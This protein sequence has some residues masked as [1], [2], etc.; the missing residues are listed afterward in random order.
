VIGFRPWPSYDKEISV[1]LNRE[2][3]GGLQR[4]FGHFEEETE[5]LN[6]PRIR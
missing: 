3:M 4:F 2:E 6:T 1:V 5:A